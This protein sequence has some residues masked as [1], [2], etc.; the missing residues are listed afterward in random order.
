MIDV[1]GLGLLDPIP[2]SE[3]QIFLFQD[4]VYFRCGE[5]SGSCFILSPASVLIQVGEVFKRS[6]FVISRGMFMAVSG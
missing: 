2:C 3:S 6:V 1:V 5:D 4:T